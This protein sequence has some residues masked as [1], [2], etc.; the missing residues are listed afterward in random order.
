MAGACGPKLEL[1]VSVKPL[2]V[3]RFAIAITA[4]FLTTGLASPAAAVSHCQAFPKVDA[5]GDYDHT[6]V[7][8]IVRTRLNGDWDRYIAFLDERLRLI[9][10]VH[11]QGRSLALTHANRRYEFSGIE[12]G[13]YVGAAEQRLNI[14]KCLA[15]EASITKL[16]EFSTAAGP[17]E[18]PAGDNQV[19]ELKTSGFDLNIETSCDAGLATFKI[20]NRGETWPMRGTIGIYRLGSGEPLQVHARS[21]RFSG[22]QTMTFRVPAN[23]NPTGKLGMFVNPSWVKRPF[24]IDRSVTCL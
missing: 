13:I 15:R 5:W 14:V 3:S 1:R 8:E 23:K 24:T 18:L 16:N 10:D 7:N 4:L 11:K 2:R 12:L 22:E 9:R 20:T 6:R 21:M 17:S 19:A